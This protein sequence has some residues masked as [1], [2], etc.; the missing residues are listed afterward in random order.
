MATDPASDWDPRWSPD[1]REIA[2]H[3]YRSGNRD[4]WVMPVSGGPARQMTEH[5]SSDVAPRWSPDGEEIVFASNREGSVDVWSIP[6]PG[7]ELRQVTNSPD[8]LLATSW[9]P[10]GSSLLVVSLSDFRLWRVPAKGGELEPITDGP[11]GGTVVVGEKIYF[12]GTGESV[13]DLWM[14]SLDDGKEHPVT[15]FSDRRGSVGFVG[16]DS[17]GKYIYFPWEESLGDIWVMDVVTDESE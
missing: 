4:I 6:A 11:V 2:F 3:S 5:E 9:M 17:D 14:L 7:G 16:L 12:A 1:G 15:D 13:S 8:N 10:D